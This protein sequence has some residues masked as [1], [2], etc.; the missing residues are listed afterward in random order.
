MPNGP[1]PATRD[2]HLAALVDEYQQLTDL[3]LETD[4]DDRLREL[5]I[6][7]SEWSERGSRVIVALA[8]KYGAFALTHAL[9]LAEALEIE[10]GIS[11]L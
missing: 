3:L 6:R 11:G 8:R 10:D 5:L 2:P 4:G 9:A 1:I 7:H